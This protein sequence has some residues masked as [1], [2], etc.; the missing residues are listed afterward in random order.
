M[1]PAITLSRREDVCDFIPLDIVESATDWSVTERERQ[2]GARYIAYADA[3]T[4]TGRDSFTLAV[5]HAETDRKVIIDLIR[6]RK[7]RFVFADVVRE[8][9]AL[10]RSWGIHEVFS[11]RFGAGLCTDEWARNGIRPRDC[12]NTTAENYIASLPLLTSGR[13]RLVDN[14]TLRSQL[15][16]LERKV[17]GGHETVSHPRA[18]SAHDDV[19]TSVCGALVC[20]LARQPLIISRE[21]LLRAATM[22]P[23][24]RDAGLWATRSMRLPFTRL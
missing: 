10:L 21:L 22:P 1:K 20:A 23:A 18:A 2:A 19:A 9:A 5:A 3:A 24:R 17:E 14:A 13:A 11:D 4:G 15:T 7:P 6:E 8:W 12:E 16:S